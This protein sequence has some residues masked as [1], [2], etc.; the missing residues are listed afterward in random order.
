M[1]C[2]CK[3][4]ICCTDAKGIVLPEEMERFRE[5]IEPESFGKETVDEL[6]YVSQVLSDGR[7]I[8][9]P[10]VSADMDSVFGDYYS[11]VERGE[12]DEIIVRGSCIFLDE[13]RCMIYSERP[14]YCRIFTCD[15]VKGTE[16]V[17]KYMKRHGLGF[18]V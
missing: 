1:E 13:N 3:D 8:W 14:E 18:M 16:A 5:V 6:F 7:K 9:R 10:R 15:P 4:V 2:S 12:A 11:L 17:K